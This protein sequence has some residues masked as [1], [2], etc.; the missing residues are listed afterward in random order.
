MIKKKNPKLEL[1]TSRKVFFQLG[2]FI[3]GSATLLA[4]TYKTPVYLSNKKHVEQIEADIP[5]I[6]V[7]KEPLPIVEIPKVETLSKQQATTPVFSTDLLNNIKTTTSTTSDPTLAVTTTDPVKLM[8]TF[9]VDPGFAP[10][11]VLIEY[12]D[13][14]AEFQGNWLGYLENNVKYP[15]ESV[16][17]GESGTA[18]VGF[19]V[20]VDGTISDVKVKNTSLSK[21]L[22]KEAIRVVKASPKWKPGIKNGE[23][24]RSTLVVKI[25]FVLE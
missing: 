6:L 10:E 5:I 2:L 23:L 25:N 12:P 8:G 20:E 3:V 16:L 4:F 18:W 13:H 24:V 21:N 7:E 22:Q 15:Q 17:F 19:V 14:N 1:E 11:G 9:S